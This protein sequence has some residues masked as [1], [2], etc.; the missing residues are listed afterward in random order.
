MD[1]NTRILLFGFIILVVSGISFSLFDFGITGKPTENIEE[2]S[3]YIWFKYFYDR[4]QEIESVTDQ[5]IVGPLDRNLDPVSDIEN[6]KTI[7]GKL[8]SFILDLKKKAI[9]NREDVKPK[10]KIYLPNKL[11]IYPDENIGFSIA[12][13]SK[14]YDIER[15]EL[16]LEKE[17]EED[18][19]LDVVLDF[20]NLRLSGV[21]DVLWRVAPNYEKIKEFE[22][23]T[24]LVLKLTDKSG[25][26]S[27]SRIKIKLI[28][29]LEREENFIEFP[30]EISI[31]EAINIENKIKEKDSPETPEG[32]KTAQPEG[33]GRVAPTDVREKKEEEKNPPAFVE[34]DQDPPP[35]EDQFEGCV[36]KL[37][38]TGYLDPDL[39]YPGESDG[40][41]APS[42]L[43][44]PMTKLG[45][46]EGPILFGNI[47]GLYH[48]GWNFEIHAKANPDK[49]KEG[50]FAKGTTETKKAFSNSN[51]DHES[52]NNDKKYGYGGGS[53]FPDDY[54]NKAGYWQYLPEHF[55][56]EYNRYH[57]KQ[58]KLDIIHWM[59]GPNI[60]LPSGY[61]EA[62]VDRNFLSVI[63]SKDGKD[64]CACLFDQHILAKNNNILMGVLN[65]LQNPN[66]DVIKNEIVPL[67]G[68]KCIVVLNAGEKN[69][70]KFL[71]NEFKP[72]GYNLK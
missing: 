40:S 35:D 44:G 26:Q 57:L 20:L 14:N 18:F 49:Y 54:S 46:S 45:S 59:D 50:Q 68:I 52:F 53:W 4:D 51:V 60:D 58:H 6:V 47:L 11:Q 67:G 24:Y 56:P 28:R 66:F 65:P 43:P 71:L 23:E 34:D 70:K 61:E 5:S 39:A 63:V 8:R 32:D 62:K 22:G 33:D 31:D 1:K 9:I 42:I 13:L 41:P 27:E 55:K 19:K 29:D 7:K 3:R 21:A 16:F 25:K 12:D 10:P 36:M 30:G 37:I 15:A 69:E 48:I 38:L 17:G 2:S 72:S 64:T